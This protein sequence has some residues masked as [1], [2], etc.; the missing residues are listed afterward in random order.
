LTE[1]YWERQRRIDAKIPPMGRREYLRKY[2]NGGPERWSGNPDSDSYREFRAAIKRRDKEARR[3]GWIKFWRAL[4][5]LAVLFA[6]VWVT[7]G[8]SQAILVVLV[9]VICFGFVEMMMNVPY[10]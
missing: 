5:G 1:N 2:P 7:M 3:E 9:L 8:L 4:A 10:R 6:V